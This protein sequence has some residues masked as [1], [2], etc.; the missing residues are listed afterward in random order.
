MNL[1]QRFFAKALASLMLAGLCLCFT[2]RVAGSSC[3]TS[4]PDNTGTGWT[5]GG[6]EDMSL[7]VGG[8]LC[9]YTVCWCY[10]Y[11]SSVNTF[12]YTISHI[13]KKD[14]ACGINIITVNTNELVNAAL[15]KLQLQDPNYGIYASH[16]PPCN[17]S[18]DPPVLYRRTDKA[19]CWEIDPPSGG[20]GG[21]AFPCGTT[22]WC[23]ST[24]SECTIGSYI[25]A[26]PMGN[27]TFEGT[28][29][30]NTI[31]CQ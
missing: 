6:C 8:Y 11:I 13:T 2:A 14:N 5:P 7:N 23:V 16:I 20:N 15:L 30:C 10:R 1:I 18:E 31:S 19:S 29:S 3:P 4:A 22:G 17:G 24:Y 9:T 21:E 26:T 12:D 28:C 27:S 25:Y